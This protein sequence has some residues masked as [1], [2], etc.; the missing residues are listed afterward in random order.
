MSG[1]R[2]LLWAVLLGAGLVGIFAQLLLQVRL[3]PEGAL[4]HRETSHRAE[5]HAVADH[6]AGGHAAE[7]TALAQGV[8]RITV[9]GLPCFDCH[10]LAHYL[11]GAPAEKTPLPAVAS[12]TEASVTLAGEA[13]DE[14][15]EEDEEDEEDE[16]PPRGSFPHALHAEEGAGHCHMCHAFKGHFQVV[17]REATCGECH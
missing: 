17:T 12:P 5:V 15:D 2:A 7:V 6:G 11:H 10:A 14:P 13:P 3:S 1:P 9:A 4:L 16:G 8:T